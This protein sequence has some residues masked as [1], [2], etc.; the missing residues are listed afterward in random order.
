MSAPHAIRD[1]PSR[2]R[3]ESAIARPSRRRTI[4]AALGVAVLAALLGLAVPTR[5]SLV[6]LAVV[7]ISA[8]PVLNA[9]PAVLI[10]LTVAFPWISRLLTSVTPGS[11]I[12]DFLDFPLV[13]LTLIVSLLAASRSRRRSHAR[14]RT[15]GRR[16]GYCVAAVF[17]SWLFRDADQPQRLLGGLLLALEPFMLLLA[18]VVAPMTDRERRGLVRLL[19]VLL[20]GQIPFSLVSIASG[21]VADDVKGTLFGAGAGHHVSVGGTALGVFLLVAL[22]VPKPVIGVV[23]AIALAI[24]ATADAKQVLFAL[25]LAL[26]VLGITARVT[27]RLALVR[28]LFLGLVMAT[29]AGY[30]IMSYQASSTALDFVDRS[31]TN[32]TGK[33]AVAEAMWQDLTAAPT[34]A[35][36]GQGP[37]ESVSRFAFLTTP[38]MA[39]PGTP[40][41]ALGLRPSRN[42]D[43]YNEIAFSGPF[44][45]NSSFTSAQSSALGIVGDY[46]TLGLVA[47][48]TLIAGLLTAVRRQHDNPLRPAALAS[49]TL[50]LVLAVIFD[51]LEQ[52][53]FTLAVMLVTGLALGPPSGLTLRRE[54]R[55]AN[56][57][58]ATVDDSGTH[59]TVQQGVMA[60]G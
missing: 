47:F 34:L 11:R 57:F 21:H 1:Q 2:T 43:R 41:R 9:R 38:E 48:S 60:H 18:V 12:L 8:L 49:W 24:A 59:S 22:H 55:P 15:L 6:V 53:P 44:T 19:V 36:F 29:V 7:A 5:P 56:P 32:R 58:A 25:P 31:T 39:R 20:C 35:A 14:R 30:A 26:F 50:L 42:A 28:G 52:P 3:E 27:G 46:G 40:A 33:V 4:G 51:W 45:G 10:G 17:L 37:G 54:A 16:L 13:L 23:G